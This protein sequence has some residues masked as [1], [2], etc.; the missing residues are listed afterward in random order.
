MQGIFPVIVSAVSKNVRFSLFFNRLT[1][2]SDMF[3][4]FLQFLCAKVA[5]TGHKLSS[6]VTRLKSGSFRCLQRQVNEYIK[7]QAAF[8]HKNN[9]ERP[10]IKLDIPCYFKAIFKM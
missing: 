7:L 2:V 8:W 1:A 3:S 5:K 6:P 4:V 9:K 10:A